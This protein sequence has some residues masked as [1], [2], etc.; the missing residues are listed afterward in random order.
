MPRPTI[1][2]CRGI[3]LGLVVTLAATGA[4]G[5]GDLKAGPR[6]AD[7]STASAAAV[8]LHHSARRRRR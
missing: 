7:E 5:L 6:T 3:A 2:R 8:S 1:A 4:L